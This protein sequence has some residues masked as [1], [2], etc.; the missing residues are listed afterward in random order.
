MAAVAATAVTAS[1][2]DAADTQK[3]TVRVWTDTNGNG[4]YDTGEPG[5]SGRRVIFSN[6][7]YT[8]SRTSAA[9]GW[10]GAVV[11][12]GC[13]TVSLGGTEA[14]TAIPI[15][16]EATRYAFLDAPIRNGWGTIN[17]A[18]ARTRSFRLCTENAWDLDAYVGLRPAGSQTLSVRVWHDVNADGRQ[19]AGEPGIGGFRLSIQ[20]IIFNRG[21]VSRVFPGKS[22]SSGGW[23][24]WSL[25][26]GTCGLVVVPGEFYNGKL[27]STFYG[28]W[29]PT[30]QRE[31][32]DG[33]DND[34]IGPGAPFC[35]ADHNVS[36]AIGLINLDDQQ[37]RTHVV[38]GTVW[39]DSNGDGIRQPSEPL[40][41]SGITINSGSRSG[42]NECREYSAPVIN[43][44]YRLNPSVG[45]RCTWVDAYGQL[46]WRSAAL[47][48]Q[49]TS[50]GGYLDAD[51]T[52]PAVRLRP[53]LTNAGPDTSDNDF[54]VQGN[55]GSEQWVFAEY[56]GPGQQ[57]TVD[58][59]LRAGTA[60]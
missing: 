38:S 22:T 28:P 2:A 25:P 34:W 26:R 31:Q 27:G 4:R 32:L 59:G 3:L 51:S 43:G 41:P 40:F 39:T 47:F 54:T 55:F 60:P 29:S 1:Q 30:A 12:V 23:A 8:T 35:V 56:Y 53:T 10:V 52:N 19:D 57:F 50:G 44:T 5:A 36:V 58:L 15:D 49:L 48:G 13:Y 37:F 45:L 20:D 6:P 14:V 7:S 18:N 21:D 33:V 46:S 11:P 9:S 42:W 16:T 17:R 24:G